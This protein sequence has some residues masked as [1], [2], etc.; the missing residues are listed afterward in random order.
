MEVIVFESAAF[1]ALIDQVTK[2]LLEEIRQIRK[3]LS[4]Q[5]TENIFMDEDEVMKLLRIT[6]RSWLCEYRVI[7]NLPCH[8]VGR[9]YVYKRAEIMNYIEKRKA[10]R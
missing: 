5:S 4:G 7:N 3:E 8:K 1:Y 2:P 6:S 10:N 9:R